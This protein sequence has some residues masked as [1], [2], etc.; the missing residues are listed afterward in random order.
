MPSDEQEIRQLVAT[1]MAATKAGDFNTD[2]LAA[3]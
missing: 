1:W 3:V 2:M